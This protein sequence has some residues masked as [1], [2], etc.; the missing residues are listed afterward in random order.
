MNQRKGKPI[1][2]LLALVSIAAMVAMLMFKPE[3]CWVTFPFVGTFVA[4][5][6]NAI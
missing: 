1:Y 4:G 5:S 3:W 6:M 2:Y